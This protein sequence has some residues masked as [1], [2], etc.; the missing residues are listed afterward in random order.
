[1]ITIENDCVGCGS[2]CCDC[3]AKHSI[4]YRCDRC[5]DDD[6]LYYFGDE[7]LCEYCLDKALSKAET[8]DGICDLC[9]ENCTIYSDYGL[10]EECFS[11]SLEIVEESE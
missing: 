2:Y 11:D 7:E 6:K 4:H 10:C 5:G 3:G 9:G 1:M 8:T